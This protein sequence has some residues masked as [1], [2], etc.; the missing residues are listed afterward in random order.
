MN[1]ILEFNSFYKK[2][3]IVLVEYW[4]NSMIT[5]VKVIEQKGNKLL[6]THNNEFSKIK[7]APD[8]LIKKSDIIDIMKN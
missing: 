4:Y 2:D 6:V 3:D 1:Y 8:E 7:N 5:P